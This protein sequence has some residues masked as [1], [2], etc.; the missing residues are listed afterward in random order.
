MRSLTLKPIIRI[1]GVIMS[2]VGLLM[3]IPTIYAIFFDMKLVP[4][5]SG[6]AFATIISGAAIFKLIPGGKPNLNK[7]QSYILVLFAWITTAL[8][9]ALP[10]MFSDI[11]FDW[12]RAF[13]ESMSGLTTTGA[14]VIDD[15]TQIPNSILL[16]RSLTQWLGGMGI[17]VLTIAIFPL[18]G[19][20]GVN[21]FSAE[22]PGPT[23]IKLHPRIKETA[24]RLWFIYVGLT[25]VLTFLL[26]FEGMTFFNAVNHALTTI[27][28]GGFSTHNESMGFYDSPLIHYTVI[29]FMFIAGMNYSLIFLSLKGSLKT[30]IQNAEL[31]SYFRMILV[32]AA[33]IVIM[34]LMSS[35]YS[36]ELSFRYALFHVVSLM[37]TTGYIMA[38]YSIWHPFITF[39]FFCLLFCGASSGSTSGGI[40]IVRHLVF[41]KNTL[42]EYKRMLHPNAILRVRID[43]DLVKRSIINNVLVFL[44]TY[45]L[46]FFVGTTLMVII[47]P[48]NS[49]TLLDAASLVATSLGNVGPAIGGEYGPTNT[50]FEVPTL[51]KYVLSMLMLIG[52]LEIFTVLIIFT[53]YFWKEN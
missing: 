53:P 46:I 36:A 44:L 11:G 24:K 50:F 4:A 38:D 17:I 43:K 7:R 41:A 29:L 37:T 20:G 45:L 25:I 6:T 28:T 16:W 1:L 52:R 3:L 22:S 42:L 27:A 18:L 19:L 33:I 40:K 47:L 13:F 14:T 5:L 48:N 34:L 10:Y 51:G 15:L 21:L 8:L 12:S 49:L 31:K 9:A 26:F 32:L 23:S 2:C 35:S 30:V 39:L